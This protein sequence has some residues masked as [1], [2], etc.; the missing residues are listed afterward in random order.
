VTL[1][2]MTQERWNAMS[3]AE[4]DAVRDLGFLTPQLIGLEGWRVEATTSYGATR[5]F[6]VS[7]SSGWRPCHIEL[8][9]KTSSG[10]FP[11]EAKY[12]SVRKIRK[13]K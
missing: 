9:T 13:E 5:R 12:V 2:E 8:K 7:R 6:I 4:K 3:A 10:G 1:A 11:A